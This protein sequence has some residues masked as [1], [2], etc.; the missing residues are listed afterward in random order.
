[1]K[2]LITKIKTEDKYF[3]KTLFKL[4]LPIMAQNLIVF[5]LNLLDSLMIGRLGETEISAV[6]LATQPYFILSLIF[7]GLG[8]GSSV[9]ISQYWGKKDTESIKH[10][11][12]FCAILSSL[13]SLIFTI[14]VLTMPVQVMRIFTNNN[15]IINISV[16]YLKIIGFTYVITSL[17]T[18]FAI[19]LRSVEILKAPLIINGFGIAINTI[20]NYLL[21]YGKAGFPKLGVEGAA[22]ATVL[23]RIVEFILMAL[24]MFKYNP[25]LKFK[26]K[27]L[28]SINK[29]L[30]N[31]FIKYSMP[32]LINEMLWG[33]GVSAQSMMVGRLSPS[34]VSSFAINSTLQQMAFITT[35]GI[36]NAIAVIVGKEVGCENYLNAKRYAKKAIK[37]V[38]F[39]AFIGSIFIFLIRGPFISLYNIT[40]DTKRLAFIIT[41]ILCIVFIFKS[42]NY[43]VIVGILRGSGD[44]K[45][46]MVIDIIF[47]WLFALPTGFIAAFILE[48]P[49][50]A[51]YIF[52]MSDE[53]IKLI[54]GLIRVFRGKYITNVTRDFN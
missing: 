10:I 49:V 38:T 45:Y 40:S 35:L 11:V 27:G 15:Q 24:Y 48:W 12:I 22:L 25:L 47:L 7:F 46:A 3:Y 4:A 43:T 2:K 41:G 29:L 19:N 23:A 42:V 50:W 33:L 44:A 31:D 13:V 17:S 34:A 32:V 39:M 28:F 1:V 37:T 8:S 26:L 21:I 5:S 30:I 14:I 16:K 51:V 52:F 20:F 6:T 54:L 36:G 18:I 53:F 9:L